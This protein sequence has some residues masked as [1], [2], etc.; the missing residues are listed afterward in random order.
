VYGTV[1][2]PLPTLQLNGN[3]R[4]QMSRLFVAPYQSCSSA[5]HPFF[6][7]QTALPESFDMERH[8]HP[9]N[10]TYPFTQHKI[11]AYQRIL[12]KDTMY[13][14]NIDFIHAQ[15][16]VYSAPVQQQ[17]QEADSRI[18]SHVYTAS[19]AAAV[20]TQIS[21]RAAASADVFAETVLHHVRPN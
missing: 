16:A 19:Q 6:L 13:R 11:R 12:D 15:Q 9:G 21:L 14:D 8:P 4:F 2:V 5:F 7:A 17:I 1:L 10:D 3:P 18:Y 20:L